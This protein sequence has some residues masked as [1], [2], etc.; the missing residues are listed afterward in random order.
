MLPP[1][2]TRLLPS[3]PALPTLTGR[4]NQRYHDDRR[5]ICGSVPFRLVSA[6]D[7]SHPPL[8]QL[9]TLRSL[10]S[11]ATNTSDWIFPKGGWESFET[12]TECAARES[13]EEAGVSGRLVGG[14]GEVEV[15]KTSKGAVGGKRGRMWMWL[16][17]V[18]CEYEDW[19]DRACRERRWMSVEEARRSIQRAEMKVILERAERLL[20]V[21]VKEVAAAML[22]GGG[23]A[24]TAEVAEVTGN[25][26][27][28]ALDKHDDDCM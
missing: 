17:Q 16:M 15:G 4:T 12:A 18:E 1:P 5:L 27:E 14:L 3:P 23:E 28:P 8:V 11:A 9:L 7:S 25:G 22:Q 19:N 6:A 10:T 24:K 26:Q 20:E 2:H 21:K 13:M